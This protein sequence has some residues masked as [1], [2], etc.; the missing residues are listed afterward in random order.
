MLRAQS[1]RRWGRFNLSGGHE[2][3]EAHARYAPAKN[4]AAKRRK[5]VKSNWNAQAKM[6]AHLCAESCIKQMHSPYRKVYDY[7]RAKWADRQTTDMHKHN[8]ALRVV[9]KEIL[10]DLYLEAKRIHQETT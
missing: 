8:H 3:L 9:S 2:A 1:C 5:G 6:R 4:V 10:K 7:E